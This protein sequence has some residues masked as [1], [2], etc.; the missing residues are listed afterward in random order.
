MHRAARRIRL[1]ALEGSGQAE[2]AII[3]MTSA[4]PTAILPVRG[5]WSA[6]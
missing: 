2:R 3:V 1:S 5:A 6:P 4:V